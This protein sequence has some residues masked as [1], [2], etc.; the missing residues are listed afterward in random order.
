MVAV[1]TRRVQPHVGRGGV[2]GE[3]E[4]LRR[5]VRR[6]VGGGLQVYC[7]PIL[8]VYEVQQ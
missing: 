1:V 7:L 5:H 6:P 4:C 3:A 2:A 8:I